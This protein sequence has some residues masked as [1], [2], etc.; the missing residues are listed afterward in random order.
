MRRPSDP[1]SPGFYSWVSNAGPF[2]GT[3]SVGPPGSGSISQRYDAG[4]GSFPFSHKGVERTQIKLKGGFF[5]SMY[6]I[7]HC[8]ICR[9]FRFQCVGGCWDRTQ[10]SCDYGV[11]DMKAAPHGYGVVMI[12]TSTDRFVQ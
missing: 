2:I 7:P 4:S 8:F 11:G 1:F 3:I 5:L 9:P 12:G 6:D 10:E